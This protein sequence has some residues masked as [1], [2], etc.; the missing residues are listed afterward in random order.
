MNNIH[1]TKVDDI[2]H[3]VSDFVRVMQD[4]MNNLHDINYYENMFPT[5]HKT[6]KTLFNFIFKECRKKNFDRN[7]FQNKLEQ[8]LVLIEK[9]QKSEISQN[10]ASE[11]VGEFLAKEYIPQLK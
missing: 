1:L 4:D 3:N 10:N 6:S 7:S 2:R 9:I 11:K 8:M 5:L